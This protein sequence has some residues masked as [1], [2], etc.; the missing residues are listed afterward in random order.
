MIVVLDSNVWLKELALDSSL[1]AA[2]R[3][4]LRQRNARLALPEVVRLEVEYNFREQLQKFISTIR[5]NH[6]Q[7]LAIFGKLKEVILPSNAEIER[8]VAEIFGGVG[9]ELVDVPF[10]FESA[11]SSF[12]KTITKLPPSDKNQQ[13]KDGVLWADCLQILQQDEVL[14]VTN[15]AAF[16]D[17]HKYEKGLA[18]NLAAEI[19]AQPHSLKI[20]SSLLELLTDLKTEITIDEDLLVQSFLDHNRKSIDLILDKNQF[21][22]EDQHIIRKV[23]Y[24]TENPSVLYI[25]FNI[26]LPC[27]D[28]SGQGRKDAILCLQADGRYN[29]DTGIYEYE[30]MRIFRHDLDFILAD[31]TK[32]QP[33]NI[34]FAVGGGV[35]GHRNVVHSIRYPLSEETVVGL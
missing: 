21:R 30:D 15:D 4:F 18:K 1:G 29:I 32:G 22:L 10:S 5:E 14:F 20:F 25:N 6:R 7:L 11:K 26:D 23:L 17:L 24:A 33:V 8:K 28:T 16:F 27:F 13:F 34:I 31:G 19:D 35:L 12:F 9:I 2:V 3:L